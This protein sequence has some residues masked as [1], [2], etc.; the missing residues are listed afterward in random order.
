M[1]GVRFG[2]WRSWDVEVSREAESLGADVGGCGM[3]T[4]GSSL[5]SF[6]VKWERKDGD[7][8]L[9]IKEEGKTMGETPPSMVDITEL[10]EPHNGAPT[11]EET[12]LRGK[13]LCSRSHSWLMAEP[14]L[15][16]IASSSG[17]VHDRST[18]N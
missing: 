12:G 10:Q 17:L 1:G 15:T 2:W 18:W 16:Q 11:G 4:C 8:G 5:L 7:E 14:S 13:G 9:D 6:A 3:E